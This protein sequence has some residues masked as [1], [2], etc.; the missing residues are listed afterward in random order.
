MHY[1]A[2][3]TN[4]FSF[5]HLKKRKQLHIHLPT[6]NQTTRYTKAKQQAKRSIFEPLQSFQEK[7]LFPNLETQQEKIETITLNKYAILYK[8]FTQNHIRKSIKNS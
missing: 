3:K 8:L 4:I 5:F 7:I 2:S 6:S 1:Y